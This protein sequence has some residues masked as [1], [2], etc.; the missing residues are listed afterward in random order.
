VSLFGTSCVAL[1]DEESCSIAQSLH[2][3]RIAVVFHDE[4]DVSEETD[5]KTKKTGNEDSISMFKQVQIM[6]N[7]G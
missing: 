2:R 7:H 4:T 6:R 5:N 1:P 3:K